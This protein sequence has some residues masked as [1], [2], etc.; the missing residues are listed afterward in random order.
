MKTSPQNYTDAD[1]YKSQ[2]TQQ[3]LQIR[4]V[5]DRNLTLR[6]EDI[7]LLIE[8]KMYYRDN[9]PVSKE[10]NLCLPN[11]YSSK[12]KGDEKSLSLFT[13]IY[14]RIDHTHCV[15]VASETS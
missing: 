5:C 10:I 9:H 2:H 6:G 4:K 12:R 11:L 7:V 14:N 1:T 15:P 3:G 13:P 8:K